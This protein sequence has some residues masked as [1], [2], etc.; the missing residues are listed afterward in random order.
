MELLINDSKF[1]QSKFFPKKCIQKKW[2]TNKSC[3]KFYPE[4]QMLKAPPLIS[5]DLHLSVL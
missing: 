1:G 2:S 5:S 4:G 3:K